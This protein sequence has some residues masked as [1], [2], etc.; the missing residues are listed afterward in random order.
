MDSTVLRSRVH[1]LSV[2]A[3]QLE[4]AR[5]AGIEQQS[6][7][8]TDVALAKGRMALGEEVARVFDAMQQ[9]AHERSVG[10]LEVLLTAVLQDVLPDEGAIRMLPQYKANTTHLDVALE[11]NG[12]LEDVIDGNGGAVTNVVSVGLRYAAL[13]RTSNRRLM[14]LDEPDCWLKPER[15]PAF[16]RTLSQVALQTGT[17]TFFITHHDPAYFEGHF[18][19]VRFA[20]EADGRVSATALLPQVTEWTDSE[21]VGIRAIELFNV[22]RHEHTLVPC[23]PGGTAYVGDNNL[24]KST[25]L[26]TSLKVVA[27]GESDDSLIRHGCDEARII[28]HLEQNKRIEW[29]R[30]IGRSPAVIY[31]L[32]EGDEL[33]AEGRPK[34]R[35]Q[36]PDWVTEVL[37]ISRVDELDIQ[38]G[39]Q[40]SPVFLLNESAP[41]R[42]QILSVGRE[43]SY[44]KDLMKGYEAMKATDREVIKQGEMSLARLKLRLGYLEKLI[45]VHTTL[46]TS[47]KQADTII[48]NLENREQLERNLKKLEEGS[49]AV[50]GLGA[51][52]LILAEVPAAPELK[53]EAELLR[54]VPV[55]E[56]SA[57]LVDIP[58]LPDAPIAPELK[59]DRDVLRMVK[60]LEGCKDLTT[61]PALPE[62]PELPVMKDLA[63][64]HA[65]G[66]ALGKSTKLE[67]CLVAMPPPLTPLPEL[68]DLEKL[69]S[70]VKSLVRSQED[71]EKG[72]KL[73]VEETA[74]VLEGEAELE[75]VKEAMGGE[76][77]LCHAP[78]TES[79]GV[80]HVH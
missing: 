78:F 73:L 42:A 55:F 37:R 68:L 40:K 52:C 79:K 72:A 33:I 30:K 70:M 76:C 74:A 46:E 25:A 1:G 59:D 18:N 77:P 20:A 17:Q 50:Q 63:A 51:E 54:L 43:S 58:E 13:V 53:S 65:I 62:V 26:L 5:K 27:Y 66:I 44:L 61:V 80:A 64:L 10:S 35:N 75:R 4:G 28:F 23:Y 14:A 36:S 67:A 8:T 47:L 9:R 12:F 57:R 3:A 39:N 16:V 29:S 2:R 34:G 32:Y 56:K 6:Q 21:Q 45:P 31:K 38:V 69:K 48:K 71:A 15:V 11:K 24:G 49:T 19:L 60:R 41:R 22:R 7:L